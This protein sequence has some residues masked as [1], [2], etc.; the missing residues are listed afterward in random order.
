MCYTILYHRICYLFHHP[1]VPIMYPRTTIPSSRDLHPHFDKGQVEIKKGTDMDKIGMVAWVDVDLTRDIIARRSTTSTV[2]TWSKLGFASQCVKHPDIAV[3]TNVWEV[4][5]WFHATKR[6]LLYR[7]IIQSM[8]IRHHAL[9]FIHKD[10]ATA[11]AQ[12]LKD[13]LTPRFKHIG[14]LISFLN[15]QYSWGHIAPIATTSNA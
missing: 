14:I 10:N 3:S 2:H 4:W 13:Q 1:L 7:S 12:A 8:R 5:S 15:E 11:T 6:T 9:T